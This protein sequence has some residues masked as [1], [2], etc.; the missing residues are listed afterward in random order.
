MIKLVLTGVWVCVVTLAAVYFSV[1]LATAPTTDPNAAKTPTQEFVK[2]EQINIPVISNDGVS[3]YFLTKV[4][5]MM[6]KDKAKDLPLPLVELTTDQLF[7]LLVGNK[8]IDIAHPNSFKLDEFRSDIKKN[9]NERLGGDYIASVLVEQIDYLSKDEI[10]SNASG[11]VKKNM[12]P[13]KV[14][15]GDPVPEGAD[16][17]TE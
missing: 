8:M 4:S 3:G 5:F 13:V 6:N 16:K 9:M 2:G 1:Q 7:T 10:R 14:V 12:K 11:P 15:Q 17:S